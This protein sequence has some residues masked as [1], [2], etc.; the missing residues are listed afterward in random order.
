M[1]VLTKTTILE[2]LNDGKLQLGHEKEKL[3]IDHVS[4][5]LPLVGKVQEIHP[6]KI[7]GLEK[8][9]TNKGIILEK[10]KKYLIG[11]F[12]I[13]LPP[14]IAAILSTKS[15]CGRIGIFERACLDGHDILDLL[16]QG[17]QGDL[18]FLVEP[19]VFSVTINNNTYI[20]QMRLIRTKRSIYEIPF[21][22]EEIKTLSISL[23]PFENNTIGYKARK[24]QEPID[25]SKNN[26]Y[27][28]REFF[29]PLYG[30]KETL[31]IKKGGFY[32]LRTIEKIRVPTGESWDI[33]PII[34]HLKDIRNHHAGFIQPGFVGEIV[35]EI[36]SHENGV[37]LANKQTISFVR[38]LKNE[39]KG[40][41]TTC[42]KSDHGFFRQKGVVLPKWFKAE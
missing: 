4:I 16:P 17:A 11:P 21:Y 5:D 31:K 33:H 19:K 38:T 13:K 12:P 18:Y 9:L 28:L 1:E 8:K 22:H 3:V 36:T 23:E 2:L 25:I 39:N 30:P 32:L 6:N 10:E 34:H 27:N 15:S 20:P 40:S 24:T 35:L 26:Y 41:E 29:E 42:E 37:E 7:N 14:G